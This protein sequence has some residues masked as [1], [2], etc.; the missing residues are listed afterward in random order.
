M[1]FLEAPF[2]VIFRL[3]LILYSY[4]KQVFHASDHLMSLIEAR[5]KSVAGTTYK[6]LKD[7]VQNIRDGRYFD[8][9]K[10]DQEAKIDEIDGKLFTCI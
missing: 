4:D 1:T 8:T 6:E 2:Y 7:L 3:C 9:N 5:E 10:Q